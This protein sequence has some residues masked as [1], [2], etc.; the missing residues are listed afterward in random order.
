MQP[1][2]NCYLFV[3]DGYSDWEPALA[4]YG[5]TNFTDTEVVTFSIDGKPV[6]S[7]GNVVVQAAKSLADL[8][9]GKIDLLLLPGGTSME[10]GHYEEILP[11]LDRHVKAQKPLAAICG[12]TVF[13]ARHG[14]LDQVQHTSNDPGY[15]KMLA[16]GYKAD[17]FYI[18]EPAVADQHIITAAGTAMVPFAQAIFQ[19]LGLLTNDQ[20]AFWLQFFLQSCA[21]EIET[22]PPFHFFYRSYQ[23]N[24][25]GLNSLVRTVAKELVREAVANELELAGPVHWHYHGF[26]GDPESLFTLEIGLPVTSTKAVP[27]PYDCKT[28]PAFQCVS[29]RHQGDWQLLSGI[30]E[31]LINGI[32]M[33]GIPMSGV[34]REIYVHCDFDNPSANITQVQ[35]GIKP[36]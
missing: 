29:A 30:Y 16:P 19:E 27:A 36:S 28:V 21:P 9:P 33:A 32:L 22:I 18:R 11:L 31:K 5:L 17:A 8:D 14:F 10:N 6:T 15:L 2:K 3:F 23:T 1:A 12:A 7:G 34:N 24:I 35:I 25:A 13:L 20:L 26:T 4:I